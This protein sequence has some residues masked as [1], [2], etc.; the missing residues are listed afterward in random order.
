MVILRTCL[1]G[2]SG[3]HNVKYNFH[4]LHTIISRNTII[5]L[6]KDKSLTLLPTLTIGTLAP[7]ILSFVFHV[8]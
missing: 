1:G 6:S 2:G 8:A 5:T 7:L 3:G 4:F